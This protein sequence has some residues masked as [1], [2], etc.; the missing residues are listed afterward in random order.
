MAHASD[1]REHYRPAMPGPAVCHAMQDNQHDRGFGAKALRPSQR[2]QLVLKFRQAHTASMRRLPRP[3]IAQPAAWL[4][5]AASLQG[6]VA[7]TQHTP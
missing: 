3:A 5:V 6:S 1:M 4:H 2:H 7:K